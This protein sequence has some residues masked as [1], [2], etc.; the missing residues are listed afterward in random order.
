[1][2]MG[3]GLEADLNHIFEQPI[4]H[5]RLRRLS[6]A[7]RKKGELLRTSTTSSSHASSSRGPSSVVELSL[8]DSPPVPKLEIGAFASR[9]PPAGGNVVKGA[10]DEAEMTC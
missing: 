1:M 7:T 6:V 2:T 9:R 4:P 8:G 5:S 3:A 10:H